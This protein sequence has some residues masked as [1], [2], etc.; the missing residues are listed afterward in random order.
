MPPQKGAPVTLR[1][2]M[3]EDMMPQKAKDAMADYRPEMPKITMPKGEKPELTGLAKARAVA[4]ENNKIPAGKPALTGRA[5]AVTKGQ[6]QKVGLRRLLG[7]PA[8]AKPNAD[9]PAK[10]RRPAGKPPYPKV[11]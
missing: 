1:R 9:K 4:D 7:L 11:R 5:L 6:G 3:D 8:L 10:G 2:R